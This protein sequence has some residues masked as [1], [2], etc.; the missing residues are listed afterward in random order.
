MN[1]QL[2]AGAN[3]VLRIPDNFE[4]D[5]RRPQVLASALRHPRKLAARFWL[6]LRREPDLQRLRASRMRAAGIAAALQEPG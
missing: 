1:R 5:F 4:P 2:F 6:E 3:A